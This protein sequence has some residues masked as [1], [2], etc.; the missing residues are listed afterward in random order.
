MEDRFCTPYL[1]VEGVLNT[2]NFLVPTELGCQLR[3]C[4]KMN[5]GLVMESLLKGKQGKAARLS[6]HPVIL[7]AMS[8]SD[9]KKSCLSS[10]P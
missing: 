1:K 5:S 8:A 6:D 10:L 7:M 9:E 4:K 3:L 2:V